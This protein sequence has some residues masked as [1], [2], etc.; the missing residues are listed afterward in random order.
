MIR[1]LEK[2]SW[3]TW[4]TTLLIAI[5]IFYISSLQFKGYSIIS[6]ISLLYHFLAFFWLAFF[7]SVSL[8]KGRNKKIIFLAL[9]LAVIY[10]LSDEIHQ[11]FVPGRVCSFF[12]LLID[13][14][15]ILLAN[16]IYLFSFSRKNNQS[17]KK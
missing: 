6:P 15:G 10:A 11:L 8:S 4:I 14:S 3:L 9:I 12:D 2:N 1:L 7:L 13:S 5:A 17:K 16:I